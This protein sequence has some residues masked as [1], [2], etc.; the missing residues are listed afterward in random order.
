LQDR[1]RFLISSRNVWAC[2]AFGHGMASKRAL[3]APPYP[4]PTAAFGAPFDDANLKFVVLD[5][6]L[7]NGVVD[8]GTD[9]EFLSFIFD[10]TVDPYDLG[11]GL[12]QPAY[13]YLARYPLT[14]EQLD[15]V[16]ELYFD[17]GLEIYSYAWP[18]WSGESEEFDIQ[19]IDGLST[20]RNLRNLGISS[21]VGHID[22]KQLIGLTHLEHLEIGVSVSNISSLLELPSL[23]KVEILSDEVFEQVQTA[24]HSTQQVF[25][26]LKRRNVSVWVHWM[27]WVGDQR[28]EAF[29]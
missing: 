21:M 24:G 5:A 13:D 16:E 23:K 22:V 20:C 1:R 12:I 28:P 14:K 6:L 15:T 2:L 11:F 18:Q 9:Y 27:T 8:L 7:S 25:Q 19:R 26:E 29:E 4:Q 17:G 3:A 10:R